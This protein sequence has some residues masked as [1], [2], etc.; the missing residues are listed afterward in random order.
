MWLSMIASASSSEDIVPSAT[1]EWDG[2]SVTS[3]NQ[4]DSQ[5]FV[6]TDNSISGS[7]NYIRHI[8]TNFSEILTVDSGSSFFNDTGPQRILRW[9]GGDFTDYE[10]D[11]TLT[12]N[13]GSGVGTG[14][15]STRNIIAAGPAVLEGTFFT[16]SPGLAASISVLIQSTYIPTGNVRTGT[17]NL[18]ITN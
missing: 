14:L 11:T 8:T 12:V 1:F 13:S 16:T 18:E 15:L 9:G 7:M 4:V 3:V 2:F 17:L 6:T 5:G 10:L